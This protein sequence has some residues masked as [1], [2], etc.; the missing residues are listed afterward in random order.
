MK[1]RKLFIG[2]LAFSV[3]V[4]FT[5]CSNFLDEELTTKR[6]TDY[7][8]TIE[9]LDGLSAG[10]YYNL[11]FH[12]SYEWAYATTNYGTDEFRCGGDASNAVWDAYDGSFSSLITA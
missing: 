12:F 5:S 9:G 6:N 7:Y 3:A 11:R 1:Y 10:M 8:N 4:G 2:L